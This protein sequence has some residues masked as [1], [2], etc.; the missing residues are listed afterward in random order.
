MAGIYLP[1]YDHPPLTGFFIMII[2][3]QASL[4]A[5]ETLTAWVSTAQG[6]IAAKKLKLLWDH[7][8]S[9]FPI[10]NMAS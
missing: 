10:P 7:R 2:N 3:A 4:N 6:N 5:T 8:D 9:A 1:T